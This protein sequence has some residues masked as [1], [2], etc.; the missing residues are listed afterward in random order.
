MAGRS[1]GRPA[2]SFSL[3][4]P[5]SGPPLFF[6]LSLRPRVAEPRAQPSTPPTALRPPACARDALPVQAHRLRVRP[7][8]PTRTLSPCAVRRPLFFRSPPRPAPLR[9]SP[10]RT[11]PRMSSA[12]A[13]A[14]RELR[15]EAYSRVL[16]CFVNS[17]HTMVGGA[18]EGRERDTKRTHASPAAH[19]ARPPLPPSL[20]PFTYAHTL[21][22]RVH[23]H[24]AAYRAEHHG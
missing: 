12:I 20:I 6:S 22:P 10:P 8:R 15:E 1:A 18:R 17:P 19:P 13:D 21:D 7:P 5:R 16:K 24:Q 3:V 9:F 11:T 4:G 14:V 2:P 23:H